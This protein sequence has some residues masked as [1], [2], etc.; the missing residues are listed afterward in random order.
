MRTRNVVLLS[1]A[2]LATVLIAIGIGFSIADSKERAAMCQAAAL[3]GG[4]P[5]RG[6]GLART[7]GCVGCHTIPGVHGA[8]GL[9]G[10]PLQGL[11]ERAYIAG[12]A[13]NTADNL[14]AWIM[15]PRRLSPRTAMP[16]LGVSEKDARD[17]AAFL[18]TR[19]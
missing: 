7:Y 5:T 12:V 2:V 3:T 15:H 16:E 19:K 1:G 11:L 9:V 13:P 6:P 4:D 17:L 8:R 10:P 14:T 18:Y